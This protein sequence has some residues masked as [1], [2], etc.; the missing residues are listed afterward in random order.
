MNLRHILKGVPFFVEFTLLLVFQ[1]G[2]KVCIKAIT[3]E[4]TTNGKSLTLELEE[5]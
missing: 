3:V 2:G 1:I 4:L 5:T